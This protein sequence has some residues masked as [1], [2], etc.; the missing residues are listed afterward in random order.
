MVRLTSKCCILSCF[1]LSL[2]DYKGI[3]HQYYSLK[4]ITDKNVKNK[5]NLNAVR[6]R[7]L[8]LCLLTWIAHV[9]H[10]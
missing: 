9:D 7:R 4:L 3:P 2:P 6:L 1:S 10:Y 5:V 8:L